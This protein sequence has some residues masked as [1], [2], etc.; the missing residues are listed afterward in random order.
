MM[1]IANRLFV[2]VL[3]ALAIGGAIYLVVRRWLAPTSGGPPAGFGGALLYV[4]IVQ[5]LGVVIVAARL[6]WRMPPWEDYVEAPQVHASSI[7][8][9][10]GHLAALVFVLWAALSMTRRRRLFPVLLRIELALLAVLPVVELFFAPAETDSYGPRARGTLRSVENRLVP[11]VERSSAVA[12]EF[13]LGLRWFARTYFDSIRTGDEVER[14]LAQVHAQGRVVHVM[15]STG[16]IRFAYLAYLLAKLGLPPLRA[17]VGLT[18]FFGLRPWR[19]LIQGPAGTATVQALEQGGS[20][21]VFLKRS[22]LTESRGRALD[23]PFPSLV[24]EARKGGRPILLLPE[25]LVWERS[26]GHVRPSLLDALF[27][28]PE[29]PS[30]ISQLM[31]FLRNYS[32]AFV[33]LGEPIN[34]TEFVAQDSTESDEVLARKVRGALSQ[35][36]SR[37]TRAIV[38]PKL[39]EPERLIE[40]V[41]RDRTF[42][43]ALEREAEEAKRPLESVES[44]ARKDLREIAA[45]YSPTFMALIRPLLSWVFN[46]LYEGVE[47]D[48]A[49]LKRALDAGIR[50]PLVFCPSHKSHIDYLLIAWVFAE[51]GMASPHAAAGANLSFFPLGTV[52]RRGGAFFLRRSFKGDRIYTATFRAYVKKLLRE[53]VSQEFYIEGG[54]SRTGKLLNPKTGLLSF[55]FDAFMEGAREDAFFVPV[56][57]DYEKIVESKAYEKELAGGEKQK[58]N[59]RGLLSAPKVLAARYGR[60]YLSFEE[61]ISLK[62][63]AALALPIRPTPMGR[64]ERQWPPSPTASSLA[65][66]A[67]RP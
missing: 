43:K 54:R 10:I 41:L 56:S 44:E 47:V 26:P 1:G 62:E 48:E 35:H 9:V 14:T 52:F 24:A 15:R 6:L 59:V 57:I 39:K 46:R 40:E 63:F 33:R 4:A 8:E 31:A 17:A 28:S 58:E 34:L 5:W 37:Q 21:L 18:R 32:R 13:G 60:I 12:R 38:G 45:K 30:G 7:A 20:A 29:A 64:S 36:L 51:R 22:A 61:P 11:S 49:G 23:D 66:I 65:S 55:E 25:L 2:E 53:G 67:P 19:R 50:G 27:G 3:L 16:R 42:H